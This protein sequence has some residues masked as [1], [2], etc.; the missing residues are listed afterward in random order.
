[1]NKIFSNYMYTLKLYLKSLLCH[2]TP[3]TL[4]DRPVRSR[5]DW[6]GHGDGEAWNPGGEGQ[7]TEEEVSICV[8]QP[9]RTLFIRQPMKALS[10]HLNLSV[11]T[12]SS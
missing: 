4:P 10:T 6:S 5:A 1:M 12:Q 11:D 8:S 2:V 7:E 3:L 9:I